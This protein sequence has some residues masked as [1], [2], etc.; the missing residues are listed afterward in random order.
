MQGAIAGDI[1][2]RVAQARLDAAAAVGLHLAGLVIRCEQHQQGQHHPR[3]GQHPE[4]RAPAEI[5]RQVTRQ[6]DAQPDS[7]RLGHIEQ[8]HHG[9]AQ[10]LRVPGADQG[11]SRGVVAGFA[12]AHQDPG[13]YQCAEGFGHT[14][15]PGGG[16]PYQ[17]HQGD[18][19]LAAVAVYR[20]TAG[21]GQQGQAQEQGARHQ[22]ELGIVEGE[23]LLDRGQHRADGEAVGVVDQVDDPDDAEPAVGLGGWNHLIRAAYCSFFPDLG[24]SLRPRL[25]FAGSFHLRSFGLQLANSVVSGV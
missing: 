5:R 1:A 15:A 6:H 2:Q 23:F 19:V 25:Q 18:H 11:V 14:G 10:A 3:Q 17:G 16:A 9:A 8:P 7:Q 21:Y 13:K 12:G 24:G 22:P 4:H 20:E